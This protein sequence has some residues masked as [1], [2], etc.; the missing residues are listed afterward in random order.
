MPYIQAVKN[1]LVRKKR[2]ILIQEHTIHFPSEGKK[3]TVIQLKRN[4]FSMALL[5]G[6]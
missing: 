1:L 4:A 5:F 3:Y 2:H 6:R